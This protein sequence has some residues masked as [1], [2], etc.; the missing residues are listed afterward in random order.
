MKL[1]KKIKQILAVAFQWNNSSLCGV[2]LSWNQQWWFLWR[3]EIWR[4]QRKTLRARTGTNNKLNPFVKSGWG[5]EPTPQEALSALH[6][7]CFRNRQPN[8]LFYNTAVK[9][10]TYT[11]LCFSL[12]FRHL[13]C[14]FRFISFC[15]PRKKKNIQWKLSNKIL[16]KP[17]NNLV[18]DMLSHER[19]PF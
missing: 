14:M 7:P 19:H 5:I 11:T 2:K 17:K 15:L 18:L 1:N 12:L 10:A 3:E 13:P 16:S 6:H 8:F 9:N 4:T